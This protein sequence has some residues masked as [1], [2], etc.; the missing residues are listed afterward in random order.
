M[1]RKDFLD[2]PS[3]YRTHSETPGEGPFLGLGFVCDTAEF[4]VEVLK[5]VSSVHHYI[6][7][8]FIHSNCLEFET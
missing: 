6:F 1:S 3:D 4:S 8:K 2:A 5:N 7:Q